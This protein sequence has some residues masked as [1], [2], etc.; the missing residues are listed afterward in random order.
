ML[1]EDTLTS[2]RI[3]LAY[4]FCS[5]VKALSDQYLYSPTSRVEWDSISVDYSI[6]FHNENN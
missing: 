3:I 6:L 5:V 4:W 2:E 1:Y